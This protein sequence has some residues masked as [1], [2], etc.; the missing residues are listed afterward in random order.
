MSLIGAPSIFHLCKT[1]VLE[2]TAWDSS[3]AGVGDDGFPLN[4]QFYAGR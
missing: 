2:N 4:A 1:I 3:T